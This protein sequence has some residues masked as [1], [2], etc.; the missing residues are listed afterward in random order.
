MTEFLNFRGELAALSSAFIWAIAAVVYLSVARSLSPLMI[1][2][3]KGVISIALLLLTILLSG[4]LA[5]NTTP[6]AVMLLMISGAIGIGMG[7]TAYFEA[8][9]CLGARRALL[10]EALAPPLTAVLA[11]VFLQEALGW[12]AWVGIGLT[13]AGVTWVVIERTPETHQKTLRPMR[14]I[15]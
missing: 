2:L 7:D 3:A 4:E 14:G 11:L 12:Q 6:I 13:I 8:L 15:A 9:Y 1:N 10:L 5:P